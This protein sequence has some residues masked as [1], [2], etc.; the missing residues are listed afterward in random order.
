[1]FNLSK[2]NNLLIQSNLG[3]SHDYKGK[4]NI[5]FLSMMRASFKML[6]KKDQ[7]LIK[8]MTLT[9]TIE[10]CQNTVYLRQFNFF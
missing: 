5:S 7:N 2:E 3:T 8:I 4:P 6:I 10:I 9:I 1:M